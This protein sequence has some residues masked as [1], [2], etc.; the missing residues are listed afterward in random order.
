MAGTALHEISKQVTATATAVD[1]VAINVKDATMGIG[2]AWMRT[3]ANLSAIALISVLFTIQQRESMQQARDDR[4]LFREVNERID[5]RA[6]NRSTRAE[7][8]HGKVMDSLTSK[9]ERAVISM[10]KATDVIERRIP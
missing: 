6:E 3:V 2:S 10:E 1:H 5:L 4:V 7:I 8:L 9:I